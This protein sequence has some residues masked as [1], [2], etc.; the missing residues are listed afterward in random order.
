MNKEKATQCLYCDNATN[1]PHFQSGCCGR[2]M[3]DECYEGDIDI[4]AQVQVDYMGDED[5]DKVKPEYQSAACLCFEC[6]GTWKNN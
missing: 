1:D 3:C 5:Y 6:H 4:T 2:G